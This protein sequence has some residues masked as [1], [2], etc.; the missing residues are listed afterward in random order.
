M[1]HRIP[2]LQRAVVGRINRKLATQ[3]RQLLKS[4][5]SQRPHFGEYYV[6]DLDA[7]KVVDSKFDLEQFARK[8]GVLMTY[9][10]LQR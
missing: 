3:K 8:L 9:E 1:K 10:A 4:S 2:V 5:K 6:V 7:G